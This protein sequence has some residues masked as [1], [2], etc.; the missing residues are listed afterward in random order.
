MYT[1]FLSEILKIRHDFGNV[2]HKEEEHKN[3]S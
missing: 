1:I 2:A 3:I